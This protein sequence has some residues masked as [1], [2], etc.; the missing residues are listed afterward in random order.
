MTRNDSPTS[1]RGP[2]YRPDLLYCKLL[3]GLPTQARGPR[4]TSTIAYAEA[5][6]VSGYESRFDF[7]VLIP[8]EGALGEWH[9]QLQQT[10]CHNRIIVKIRVNKSSK[11]SMNVQK[12][13]MQNIYTGK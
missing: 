10:P 12:Y 11:Q 2:F 6:A 8:R 13:K 3:S 4:Y 5:A 7:F 1:K 9:F